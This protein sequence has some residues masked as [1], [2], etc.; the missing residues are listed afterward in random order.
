MKLSKHQLR[1]LGMVCSNH[2]ISIPERGDRSV[3]IAHRSLRVLH[4][5]G[6]IYMSWRGDTC[7]LSGTP[8]GIEI[9]RGLPA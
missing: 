8:K 5:L 1:L 2:R 6:L 9:W 4:D 3:A 7:Y